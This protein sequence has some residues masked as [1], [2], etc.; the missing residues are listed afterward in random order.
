MIRGC[1]A[2]EETAEIPFDYI[3]DWQTGSIQLYGLRHGSGA[4][5]VFAGQKVRERRSSI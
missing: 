4:G 1:E 5:A 2:F 3:L